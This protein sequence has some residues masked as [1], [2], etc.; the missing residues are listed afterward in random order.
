MRLYKYI[1]LEKMGLLVYDKFTKAN[2]SVG[3]LM[4]ASDINWDVLPTGNL[5]DA[6]YGTVSRSNSKLYFTQNSSQASSNPIAATGIPNG[7]VAMTFNVDYSA[8]D[9]KIYFTKTEGTEDHT[10]NYQGATTAGQLKDIANKNTTVLFRKLE[11][12]QLLF[13]ACSSG[14]GGG[15]PDPATS[16]TIGGIKV[17]DN[18]DSNED[19]KVYTQI[20]STSYCG[21]VTLKAADKEHAGIVQLSD[22]TTITSDMQNQVDNKACTPKA[23]A[24]CVGTQVDSKFWT[25]TETEY[26][27]I[28][29][30]TGVIYSIYDV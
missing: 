21:F 4:N 9:Q 8:T 17:K 26:D 22:S 25:G 13:L 24:S 30:Q 16:D 6:V 1:N 7:L 28:T 11:N 23:F 5:G 15:E 27:L 14:T 18:A 29:P 3:K 20:E 10:I 12:G 19:T 2:S